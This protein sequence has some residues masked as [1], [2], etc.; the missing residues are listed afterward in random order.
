MECIL[1]YPFVPLV[2]Q[3][4]AAELFVEAQVSDVAAEAGGEED[5]PHPSVDFGLVVIKG[6]LDGLSCV[7]SCNHF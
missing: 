5:L 3:F 6:F 2:E 7:Y 1:L 4:E